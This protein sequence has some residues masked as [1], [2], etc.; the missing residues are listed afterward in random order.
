MRV[1]LG[2]DPQTESTSNR[3]LVGEETPDEQVVDDNRGRVRPRV[4][5]IEPPSGDDR[6]TDGLE[7]A[8][9]DGVGM[10]DVLSIRDAALDSESLPGAVRQAVASVDAAVPMT[11]FHT[12]PALIDRLLRTER[13]LSVI[14]AALGGIALTLA[15][16]GLA[17]LLG[18]IVA[19]RRQEIGVRMALGASAAD[20][21]RMVLR[22]SSRLIGMGLA[23]GLPCAY[24]VARVLRSLLFEL[25]P[26][27]I[28][29]T[30]MAFAVLSAVALA[31]AWLPARRAA[32]ID[33]VSALRKE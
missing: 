15:A 13:M 33:A 3:I 21:V 22:D 5:A 16:I 30:A 24:G 20:V 7:E 19:R 2:I 9:A 6:D 1:A 14:S 23:I 4:A 18:Y 28:P 32:S 25:E 12:Q 8:L 27:D 10:G 17:G 31:A 11:E 26:V 29:T